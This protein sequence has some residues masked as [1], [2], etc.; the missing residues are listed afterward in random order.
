MKF[1]ASFTF[2]LLADDEDCDADGDVGEN[3]AGPQRHRKWLHEGEHAGL[4]FLRPLDHDGDGDVHEGLGEV[5]HALAVRGDGQW[6]DSQVSQLSA[7]T[8]VSL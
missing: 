3:D 1:F 2:H 8:V 5:H 6:S 4:L 7:R